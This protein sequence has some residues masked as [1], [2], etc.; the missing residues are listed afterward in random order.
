MSTYSTGYCYVQ[1]LESASFLIL[2]SVYRAFLLTWP[3][4]LLGEKK[5]FMYEKGLIPTGFVWNTNMAAFALLW[6]TNMV[7]LIYENAL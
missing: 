4:I 2:C 5:P 1:S 7:G 6:N 3:T